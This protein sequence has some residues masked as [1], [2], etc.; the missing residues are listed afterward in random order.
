[1]GKKNAEWGMGKKKVECG[2]R[3]VE[4][5]RIPTFRHFR[6]LKVIFLLSMQKKLAKD[7]F[8]LKRTERAYFAKPATQAM[9]DI[10]SASGGSIFNLQFRLVRVR[11][12]SSF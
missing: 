1:M 6:S 5:I 4:L 11:H 12:F 8:T 3:N 2:R 9:S 7:I 10:N